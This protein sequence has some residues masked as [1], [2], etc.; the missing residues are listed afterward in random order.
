MKSRSSATKAALCI[1]GLRLWPTGCPTRASNPVLPLIIPLDMPPIIEG[2]RWLSRR[3]TQGSADVVI[4]DGRG[5]GPRG[6]AAPS[7]RGSGR[8]LSTH[9]VAPYRQICRTPSGR[10]DPYLRTHLLLLFAFGED[11]PSHG[12]GGVCRGRPTVD[13]ALEEDF[14][15]LLWREAVADG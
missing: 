12:E 15:Y 8:S 5:S 2:G 6:T 1:A 13:G 7:R 14:S 4:G 9:R 3:S 11:A 10:G